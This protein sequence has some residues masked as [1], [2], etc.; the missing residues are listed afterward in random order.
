LEL[1]L[2][3]GSYLWPTDENIYFS[4]SPRRF[5]PFKNAKLPSNV[6]E[7]FDVETHHAGIN[8][9]ISADF[10]VVMTTHSFEWYI[11]QCICFAH[12]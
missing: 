10:S 7:G 4:I 3:F 9:E 8:T 6:Q 11:S 5:F 1:W 12:Y 2:P